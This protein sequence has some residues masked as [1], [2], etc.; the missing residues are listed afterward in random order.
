MT[1]NNSN[2]DITN[3]ND[4]E[5]VF[6]YSQHKNDFETNSEKTKID[7]KIEK[8]IQ[9][10]QDLKDGKIKLRKKS[11]VKK[12][13]NITMIILTIIAL[14]GVI[15]MYFMINNGGTVDQITATTK[16]IKTTSHMEKGTKQIKSNQPQPTKEPKQT[17]TVKEPTEAKKTINETN[18]KPKTVNGSE[19]I[20]ESPERTQISFYDLKADK[21]YG[22]NNDHESRAALSIIKMYI[23]DHVYRFGT[24]NDKQQAY[25]MLQYS[26]DNIASTL[27]AKYPNS[28]SESINTYNLEN[29]YAAAHWGYST[30]STADS[31]KYITQKLKNNPE[32]PILDALKNVQPIAADGY[33]QNYGTSTLPGIIGTKFGWSDDRI[34]TNASVSYGKDFV[35]AANT[36][37][38][39][40][41]LTTD[42][43]QIF[44]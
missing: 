29:T 20:I 2:N 37:G 11:S 31:V 41:Q 28:I 19:N 32:S 38:N 21:Y 27:Y 39:A 34:T 22:S 13:I 3:N 25:Q 16:N 36:L 33:A 5:K 4:S 14:I 24:D 9:Y 42:V 10:K 17:Q 26:D 1:E 12:K 6:E 15:T 35:V 43:Q 18:L 40:T 44:N 23:A 30:T 7:E 8:E